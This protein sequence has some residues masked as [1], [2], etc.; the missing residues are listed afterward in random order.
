FHP[1]ILLL[2]EP[3]SNLDVKLREEMRSEI[4]DLQQR[5]KVTALYVTHDQSE[6]LALS[7]HVA[8]M[9]HGRIVQYGPPRHIYDRPANRFVA[10]FV[11]W[12][13]VLDGEVADSQT[14]LV[15]GHAIPCAVPAG[16]TRGDR[17]R[18]SL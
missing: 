15:D 4:R 18:V 3:L 14:V 7:D 2:D 17:V 16:A 8:V 11:G 1:R 5:L 9:D 12:T 6:A 10:D 13:N